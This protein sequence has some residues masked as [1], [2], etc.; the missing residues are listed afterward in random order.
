MMKCPSCGETSK[1][2]TIVCP[3]CGRYCGRT[4]AA[5]NEEVFSSR[6]RTPHNG[7]YTQQTHPKNNSEHI[8]SGVKQDI[9]KYD[10]MF[11]STDRKQHWGKDL[12]KNGNFLHKSDS[13]PYDSSVYKENE[14]PSQSRKEAH[15]SEFVAEDIVKFSRHRF[16]RDLANL[17]EF[18]IL[19]VFAADLICLVFDLIIDATRVTAL[20]LLVYTFLLTV[21]SIIA[22]KT[23]RRFSAVCISALTV[24]YTVVMM[25]AVIKI[26]S[27]ENAQE[28]YFIYFP[29]A[30][31]DILCVKLTLA[32]SKYHDHWEAYKQRGIYLIE[33][34]LKDDYEFYSKQTDDELK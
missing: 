21:F 10:D 29:I 12:K 6:N 7:G 15:T 4:F 14:I 31:Q 28:L 9:G 25:I 33:E 32:M 34:D 8:T 1:N 2:G 22:A 13:N 17:I 18:Y 20:I 26:H 11:F 30:A 3:R 16:A 27:V 23:Y 24:I 5:G 19:G